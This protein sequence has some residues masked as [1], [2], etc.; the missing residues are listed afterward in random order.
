MRQRFLRLD[1]RSDSEHVCNPLSS[2]GYWCKLVMVFVIDMA[3][4]D[5]RHQTRR[6]VRRRRSSRVK[7]LW[8]RGIPRHF[9]GVAVGQHHDALEFVAPAHDAQQKLVRQLAR[10]PNRTDNESAKM[11]TGKGVIQGY[12][13][14]TAV[15]SKHQIIIE[16]QAHGTGSEQELLM[17]VMTALQ[18]LLA[19][20]TIIAA[21]AG[22]HSEANLQQLATMRVP[23]LIADNEMRR[24]DARKGVAALCMGGGNGVAVAVERA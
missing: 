7:A 2:I 20:Q 19:E 15:D 23:A 9:F 8:Q 17:P 1:W 21:D 6:V 24:R 13:G 5:G 14:V 11:A 12:T 16:A 22:Y 18:E 10:L 4:Y 3:L